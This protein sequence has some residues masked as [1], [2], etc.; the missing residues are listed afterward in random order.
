MVVVVAKEDA[1]RTL[2]LFTGLGVEAREIGQIV[3]RTA[4]EPQTVVV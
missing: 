4:G 3:E 1:E 2:E